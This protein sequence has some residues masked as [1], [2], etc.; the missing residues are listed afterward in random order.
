MLGINIMKIIVKI[1]ISVCLF[2]IGLVILTPTTFAKQTISQAQSNLDTV[3]DQTGIVSEDTKNVPA[4][5]GT[6]VSMALSVVAVV[7]F[8]LMVYAGIKWLVSRG[9]EEQIKK[10]RSTIIGATIGLVVII[11]AYAFTQFVQE[12]IIEGQGQGQPI[13][14]QNQ[15]EIGSDAGGGVV[16]CCVDTV[17]AAG[18]LW[19]IPKSACRITTSKDCETRGLTCETGDNF[20]TNEDWEFDES[21]TD[22]AS[23]IDKYCD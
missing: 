13:A 15:I 17:G 23:C 9:D 10:A 19:S 6:I 12:R 1:F 4:V 7:F 11:S 21:I 16:G 18:T 22:I 3:V 2:S 8:A 20:C 14:S 5:V